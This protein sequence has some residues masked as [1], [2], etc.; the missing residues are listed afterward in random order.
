VKIAGFS[1][2]KIENY[3]DSEAELSML[4]GMASEEVKTRVR[5]LT[6]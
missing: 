5:I 2:Q 4:L 1:I 6:G 3:S